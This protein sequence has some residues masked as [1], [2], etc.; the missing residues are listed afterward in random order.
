MTVLIGKTLYIC[1]S[2]LHPSVGDL[3]VYNKKEVM[4]FDRHEIW[5]PELCWK[6]LAKKEIGKQ[7]RK[8]E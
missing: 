6:I 7:K 8:K 1:S 3:C 4:P 2:T 5:N